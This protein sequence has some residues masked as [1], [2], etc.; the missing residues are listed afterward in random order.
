MQEFSKEIQEKLKVFKSDKIKIKKPTISKDYK[1]VYNVG[2]KTI[3]TFGK[4]TKK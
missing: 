3:L 1:P 4:G 2:T